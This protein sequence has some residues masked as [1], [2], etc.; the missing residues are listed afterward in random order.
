M[1]LTLRFYLACIFGGIGIKLVD[2]NA[3]PNLSYGLI[4]VGL[5]FMLFE[6]IMQMRIDRNKRDRALEREY[7]Q[8]LQD[9][10]GK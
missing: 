2:A 7:K 10:R 4:I 1:K 6:C 3:N 9:Y 5:I 8:Y